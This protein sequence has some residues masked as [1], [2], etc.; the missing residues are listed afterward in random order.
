MQ[1]HHQDDR[2]EFSTYRRS[3]AM[4]CGVVAAVLAS[5]TQILASVAICCCGAC[6]MTKGAKRI[7]AVVFFIISWYINNLVIHN[8]ISG[9]F[10]SLIKENIVIKFNATIN[11]SLMAW[12]AMWWRGPR[13]LEFIVLLSFL[14]EFE[15]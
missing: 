2:G 4:T 1:K 13:A 12:C 14:L 9:Y 8:S 7:A 6:R 5:M 3:P 10:L 15:K 11:T